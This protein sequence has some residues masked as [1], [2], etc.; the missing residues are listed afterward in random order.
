MSREPF[1]RMLEAMRLSALT[2]VV[3]DF[4]ILEHKLNFGQAIGVLSN[5]TAKA[6][7]FS[8]ISEGKLNEF[9]QGLFE[10]L[11]KM[12]LEYLSEVKNI[13]EEKKQ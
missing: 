11:K 13:K 8:N 2:K 1:E 12:T 10:L 9:L 6:I 5:A 7:A 4:L 3:T